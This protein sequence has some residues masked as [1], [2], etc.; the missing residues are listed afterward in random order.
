MHCDRVTSTKID[1]FLNYQ[2]KGDLQDMIETQGN[3]DIITPLSN[4]LK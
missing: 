4:T 3:Y 2:F 1:T